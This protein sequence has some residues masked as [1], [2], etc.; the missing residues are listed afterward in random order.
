MT[1]KELLE[2]RAALILEASKLMDTAQA[3]SRS[4]SAEEEQKFD[5]LMADADGVDVQLN[6]LRRQATL[7]AKKGELSKP[8]ARIASAAR[9]AANHS[10]DE[11]RAA[12]FNYL[13]T[14]DRSEVR[15][16]SISGSSGYTVP[17]TT[18]A[19]IVEKLYQDS[20]VRQIATVR[21]TPDDRKIPLE[22]GVPTAAIIGETSSITASDATFGQATVDAYKYASRVVASRELLDD[23]A[24]D[25]ESYLI[26]RMTLAIA[27]DQDEDFWDG[28]DSS[29]P[30]GVIQ[31]MT[32][33]TSEKY[34][35][36]AGQT[37]S[38][39]VADDIMDW[40]YLLPPQYRAGAVILTSDEVIK[41]LRKIKQNSQYIW[42]SSS[43]ETLLAGGA[44]GTIMGIPY[45]ISAYPDALAAS[46]Y[47]AVYGNFRYYEIF[48]RGA[49]EILVDP[50]TNASTWQVQM[51]A[52]RRTDAVR[53][54]DDA[55]RVLQ[56]SA[57]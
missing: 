5:R 21:Q 38:I 3:D 19:R 9:Q 41:N 46:K 32:T 17:T 26:D 57:T 24:F 50:Y 20:I 52:V 15:A 45:Y 7:A 10:D 36:S 54:N 2:Q 23:S 48:D 53:T 28:T 16:M 40:I 22:T 44:P 4:L 1:Q 39:T 35:L 34:Q 51:M 12:F 49:T 37:T 42:L 27:R 56:C 14:G 43:T 18:E 8:A 25:L 6:Q 29:M 11:Y 30:Q 47:V 33:A 13:R 55:F 31:G